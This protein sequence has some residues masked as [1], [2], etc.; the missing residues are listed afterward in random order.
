LCTF[1][2]ARWHG[3]QQYHTER[4]PAQAYRSAVFVVYFSGIA[5]SGLA[6][7]LLSILAQAFTGDET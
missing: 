2:F 4:Q 3:A 6:H 7:A 1:Q 5:H